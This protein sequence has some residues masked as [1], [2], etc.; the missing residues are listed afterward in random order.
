MITDITEHTQANPIERIGSPQVTIK[1]INPV[2]NDRH[3][4]QS[5]GL[6]RLGLLLPHISRLYHRSD[7]A[8]NHMMVCGMLDSSANNKLKQIIS[9]Q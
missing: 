3:N 5:N 6:I 1:K 9:I 2:Q 4:E 8:R 7:L